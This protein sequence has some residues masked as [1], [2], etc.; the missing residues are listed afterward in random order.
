[1]GRPPA[2]GADAGELTRLFGVVNALG[3]IA[4]GARDAALALATP[5]GGKVTV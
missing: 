3:V 4:A 2:T 1:M 5:Q